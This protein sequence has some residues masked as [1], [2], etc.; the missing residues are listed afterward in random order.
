MRISANSLFYTTKYNLQF[1]NPVSVNNG[2]ILLE[3]NSYD[4]V[5]VNIDDE[6][7]RL[8]LDITIIEIIDLYINRYFK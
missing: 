5:L 1:K 3:I 7:Y 8:I 4:F 2:K 6:E